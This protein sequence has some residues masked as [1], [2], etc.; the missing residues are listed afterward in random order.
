[1]NA[2]AGLDS[3]TKERRWRSSIKQKHV[4]V[5]RFLRILGVG[6]TNAQLDAEGIEHHVHKDTV[7][8]MER[9]VDFVGNH[10]S[11]FKV[12]EDAK[13]RNS[14]GYPRVRGVINRI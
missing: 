2:I 5:I 10:P 3:Q 9:F 8:R 14:K 11:W 12:F 4:T 1:M 13:N 7:N 6:E